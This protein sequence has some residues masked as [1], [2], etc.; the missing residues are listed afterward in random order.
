MKRSNSPRVTGLPAISSTTRDSGG[1]SWAHPKNAI[2]MTMEASFA[3]MTFTRFG[4]GF[5][6]V[7][8]E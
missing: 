5:P 4:R 8:L 2:R 3:G 1:R 6:Y 7:I